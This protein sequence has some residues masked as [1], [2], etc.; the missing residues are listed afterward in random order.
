[1][2]DNLDEGISVSPR[3]F[4]TWC[5]EAWWGKI[6]K[7][8]TELLKE[9]P[10]FA[11]KYSDIREGAKRKWVEL[12]GGKPPCENNPET[13]G[14]VTNIGYMYDQPLMTLC[15]RKMIIWLQ[16]YF[17]HGQDFS[18]AAQ[19]DWFEDSDG[20]ES[21]GF[22][23]SILGS[24]F[25]TTTLVHE[26][27]HINAMAHPE[28]ITKVTPVISE[29][30]SIMILSFLIASH[31]YFKADVKTS[32]CPKGAYGWIC[33]TNLAINDPDSALINAGKFAAICSE[34]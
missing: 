13:M 5:S 28:E 16:A 8:D 17:D 2:I 23:I 9:R 12:P 29:Y 11:G 24:A 26:L 15:P 1:M 33:I 6:E 4:N 21:A 34:Q 32:S 14:Y 7:W 20:V 10:D 3:L 27:T 25:L 31:L 18:T 30:A 22:H 19:A